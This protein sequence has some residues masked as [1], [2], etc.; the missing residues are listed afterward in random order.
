MRVFV[1]HHSADA[2]VAQQIAVH[3]HRS[4]ASTFLDCFDIR[5]GDEFWEVIRTAAFECDDL[6]VL[7]TPKAVE[8]YNIWVEI[9]MF[10]SQRKRITGV[11]YGLDGTALTAD[12][13]I[14]VFLKSRDLVDINR[15]ESYFEQLSERFSES[16][17]R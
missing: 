6:L 10:F 2:W 15:I 8:R 9:G 14:P 7:L 1:S 11:L 13:R 17:A 3:I 5:H 4:C 12:E 16:A